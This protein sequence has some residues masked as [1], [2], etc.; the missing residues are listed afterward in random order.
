[1]ISLLS[2]LQ[3]PSSTF[4]SLLKESYIF[5]LTF[6]KVALRYTS[7]TCFYFQFF[8][9]YDDLLAFS[10]TSIIFQL[11]VSQNQDW[12]GKFSHCFL[13]SQQGKS[14]IYLILFCRIT[15]FMS[16]KSI[17]GITLLFL[18]S[19]IKYPIFHRLYEITCRCTSF[20]ISSVI[21]F[22]HWVCFSE[23]IYAFSSQSLHES[24]FNKA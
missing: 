10:H 23:I 6:F 17:Q 2:T 15:E 20:L 18:S 3:S 13:Y 5:L 14:M 11:V 4:Q 24:C 19:S 21:P 12:K 8:T 1:M 7:C 9:S 16:M 22:L